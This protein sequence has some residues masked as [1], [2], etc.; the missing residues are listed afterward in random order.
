M[1][2][3]PS[4]LSVE[5]GNQ[6]HVEWAVT[7]SY[8]DAVNIAS[9]QTLI[10]NARLLDFSLL[11]LPVN[12]QNT[13]RILLLV[14]VGALIIVFLRNIVGIRTFGTFMPVLIA[15]SFRETE[16]IGGLV[17]FTLIVSLGLAIRFYLEHLK[18]LLV[19]R[20]AAVVIIVVGLMAMLSVL[21]YNLGLDVGLAITLFPMVILAM[22]IER[23]SIV[24]EEHGPADSIRQG[25][26][27]LV[28]AA[29]SYGVMINPYV[30]HLF[31]M[32]PELIL[33]VLALTLLMG[34]YT[35][36]RL[37]ELI[38]FRAFAKS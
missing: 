11:N 22:T 12:T 8:Q 24:W 35:G 18:L 25:F 33:I 3:L 21:S 6:A 15:L 29:A 4:A 38:R 36:Y 16:L 2:D 30:E 37:T 23:M 14:P 9:Q 10:H 34:R 13:Y 20:L 26:G 28:V 32:F 7:R 31:F 1:G 27:S 19:P 17:L 5:R